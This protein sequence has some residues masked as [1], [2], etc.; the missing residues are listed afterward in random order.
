MTF[1]DFDPGETLFFSVDVDPNS[2]QG[3]APP[4]PGESGSVAG[5]ELI[6]SALS[7]SFGSTTVTG[8]LFK[9]G[10]GAGGAVGVGATNLAAE[11]T[12][13]VV[14]V[15]GS[16]ATVGAALQT[17]QITG[18]ANA[19]VRVL[20][21]EGAQFTAG[22]PAAA[23]DLGEYEANSALISSVLDVTLDANGIA[24]VQVTLTRSVAE[25]GLNYI[26]A[27]VL[28]TDGTLG[29]VSAPSARRLVEAPQ[30]GV[31]VV[32]SGGST[33]VTEGGATDSFTVVLQSQP[34]SNVMVTVNGTADVSVAA[35]GGAAGSSTTLTFTPQN[36]NVAQT[37]TVTAVNDTLVEGSETAS[38]TFT[39]ASTDAA[40]SGMVVPAVSA[41]VTDDDQ[42]PVQPVVVDTTSALV[43]S[44]GAQSWGAVAVSATSW[45]G[46]A[47]LVTF[48]SKDGLG[49]QGGRFAGQVDY[50]TSAQASE[51][52]RLGFGQD[53]DSA[54]IR[55]A[56]LNP[57]E[58]GGKAEMGTWK[59]YDATGVLV[60]QGILDPRGQTSVAKH[61]YDF[62]IGPVQDFAFLEL[63]ALPYNNNPA[64]TT[65][66]D[67]S[68]FALL[69]VA[70][71]PD[72]LF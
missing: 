42:A 31:T 64:S 46:Q 17:V 70:Y 41:A 38:V 68:D 61:V 71:V 48:S 26:S 23:P 43:G 33:A 47:A 50:N 55:L 39:L 45:T 14:G 27:A 66:N 37:V 44:L 20:L 15:A 63:S 2:I 60:G 7:F 72:A 29:L 34:T 32:L 69:R 24:Q 56:K 25:G 1:Q 36:W 16:A 3:T 9:G 18:P 58:A 22:V 49:V 6:G 12:V 67:N 62:V 21:L 57:S 11:P 51:V 53:I 54:T 30:A 4:G 5:V 19:T 52:L 65:G 28:G 59:A 8:E 35:G 40:Y 13:S 10:T